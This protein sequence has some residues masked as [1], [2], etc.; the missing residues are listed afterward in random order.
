MIQNMHIRAD[1]PN[2]GIALKE[3]TRVSTLCGKMTAVKFAGIPGATPG[4]YAMYESEG[5]YGWCLECCKVYI[6]EV[7]LL[8][9][10]IAGSDADELIKLYHRALKDIIH[11][12]DL[13]N[14]VRSPK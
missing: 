6:V 12:I 3:K 1:Y 10:K 5:N 2:W 8:A 13:A 7:R 9:E 14:V 11:Q 4:Q